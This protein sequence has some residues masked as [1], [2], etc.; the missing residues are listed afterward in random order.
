MPNAKSFLRA[1]SWAA[2][3]AVVAIAFAA[4]AARAG[5]VKV[6]VAANFTDTVK[7]IGAL[8]EK[9]TGH[10]PV[11]SFGSTGQLEVRRNTLHNLEVNGGPANA[12][13][14]DNTVAEPRRSTGSI[15]ATTS[16]APS[17]GP[18]SRR[19]APTRS[20]SPAK[21]RRT[22]R[23]SRVKRSRSCAQTGSLRSRPRRRSTTICWA[24]RRRSSICRSSSA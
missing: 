10:K 21:R 13:I 2:A 19:R 17:S 15:C 14:A 24:F 18:S 5:E 11:F 16:G 23:P 6:A 9:A 12:I 4:T 3:A 7:E 8:F 1:R 22:S 20:R